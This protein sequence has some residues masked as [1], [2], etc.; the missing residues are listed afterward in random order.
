M[1]SA[2]RF[3]SQGDEK[4]TA[5]L[6]EKLFGDRVNEH[7]LWLSVRAFLAHQRQGT[8]SVKNRANIRGGGRKP[9]RQ[10]GTGMARQGTRRSPLMKGG[11]RAFGPHPREYRVRLPRK[12][13]ALGLRSALSLAAQEDRIMVVEDFKLVKP[14]TRTV[15]GFLDRAGIGSDKCLIVTG[16]ADRALVLSGRNI[17]KVR[18]TTV[19][20][21][22]AYHL[23]NC[24]KV[25]MTESALGK[26]EEVHS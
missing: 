7:V 2:K 12:V 16:T 21:L 26:L 3:T 17:P 15:A 6:P 22:N 1:I 10:K 8:A 18:V 14:Q 11:A 24:E 9:F 25:I 19:G 23:L 13:R 4:G 20:E 5:D